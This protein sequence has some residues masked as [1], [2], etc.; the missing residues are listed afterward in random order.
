MES[1]AV[2]VCSEE[3][4]CMSCVQRVCVLCQRCLDG[5]YVA[6]NAFYGLQRKRGLFKPFEI[7]VITAA[8][9]CNFATVIHF[10]DYTFLF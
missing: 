9:L 5:H 3:E 1:F 10:V 8:R 6:K 7:S 2:V 4:L